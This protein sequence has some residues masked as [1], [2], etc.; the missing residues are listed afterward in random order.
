MNEDK[1]MRRNE[2]LTNHVQPPTRLNR[3]FWLLM[4]VGYLSPNER[5]V[6]YRRHEWN[7]LQNKT[8]LLGREKGK[9]CFT[10]RSE[11]FFVESFFSFG[12]QKRG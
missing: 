1:T 7:E 2:E 12:F 6:Q 4:L 5:N 9:M 10:L 11:R 8:E 3:P